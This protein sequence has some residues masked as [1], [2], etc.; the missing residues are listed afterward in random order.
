[1][2]SRAA[3]GVFSDTDLEPRLTEAIRASVNSRTKTYVYVLPTQVLAKHIQPKADARCLQAKRGGRGAF[4]ARTLC[5]SAIVHFDKQHD[6]VLGGSAEPYVN[7]PLRVPELTRKYR[8]AQKDKVGWD[9]LCYVLG[10]VERV[11][12]PAF[13]LKVLRQVL[14]EVYRRLEQT[15][16]ITRSTK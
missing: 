16:V 11:N 15:R 2:E 5:H 1:M 10:Q 3:G 7:N 6:N 4:D 9:T 13:T 12:K 14:I 8:G